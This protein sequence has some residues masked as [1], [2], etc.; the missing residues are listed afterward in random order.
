MVPLMEA[1]RQIF[2]NTTQDA[3]DLSE[4]SKTV[5]K[6]FLAQISTKLQF[7]SFNGNT[8]TNIQKHYT[9]RISFV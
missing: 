7:G 3:Y 2:K 8:E 5:L 9:G 4:I 1:H 6:I